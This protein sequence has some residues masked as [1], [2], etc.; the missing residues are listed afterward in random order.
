MIKQ[1]GVLDWA[2]QEWT[3]KG[4]GPLATGV[5]GTAFLSCFSVLPLLLKTPSNLES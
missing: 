1:P 3:E 5:T 2:L 4:A